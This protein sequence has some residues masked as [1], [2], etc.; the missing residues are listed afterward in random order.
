MSTDA[1]ID[2]LYN[3]ILAREADAEGKAYWLDV[4]DSRSLSAAQATQVFLNSGEFATTISPLASLYY[5]TFNRAPDAPGL[6]FWASALQ[7]GSTFISISE[8][9]MASAEYQALYGGLVDNGDFIDQV[10]SNSFARAADAAG[11]AYWLAE[12]D[13]G[14]SRAELLGHFARSPELAALRGEELKVIAQ[15][16]SVLRADPGPGEFADAAAAT[17]PLQLTEQLYAHG[18][19]FGETVPYFVDTIAPTVSASL[20]QLFALHDRGVHTSITPLND[21]DNY[22][23]SSIEHHFEGGFFKDGR[24]QQL[25]TNGEVIAASLLHLDEGSQSGDRTEVAEVTALGGG[26]YVLTWHRTQYSADEPS[27]TRT[28]F[29]QHVNADGSTDNHPLIQIDGTAEEAISW[30]LTTALGS[31]GDY[32]VAWAGYYVDDADKEPRI[33]LQH[34]DPQGNPAGQQPLELALSAYAHGMHLASLDDSGHF[35]LSWHADTPASE[36]SVFGP[37]FNADGSSTGKV[38]EFN[39]DVRFI[40]DIATLGNTG[41]YAVIW[42]GLSSGKDKGHFVQVF[43]ADGSAATSATEVESSYVQ[44]TALG[45]SGEFVLTWASSFSE[46]WRTMGFAQKYN[47]DGT[48]SGNALLQLSDITGPFARAGSPDVSALG[49]DGAYVLTWE[50]KYATAVQQ[51]GADG[52]LDGNPVYFQ[53]GRDPDISAVGNKG[54]YALVWDHD[55]LGSEYSGPLLQTFN[56]DGTR[57]LDADGIIDTSGFVTAISNEQGQAYLVNREIVVTSVLDITGSADELWNESSIHISSSQI[58]ISATGLVDG[59][60]YVYSVDEAGNLSQPAEQ[61][62]IIGQ[63]LDG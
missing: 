15:Y 43:N 26:D 22:V 55:A 13:R 2:Q 41:T 4:I 62:I 18:F 10:Y 17:S 39:E 20:P 53:A 24:V 21:G 48:T 42:S 28:I 29:I 50:G 23:L 45:N 11:H 54:E 47:A 40:W 9:F 3:N 38:T 35:V 49:T 30:P 27:Y 6:A 19:Y 8:N 33:F 46:S 36:N 56:A 25:D 60:Y 12:L 37:I 58:V 1:F 61:I 14:L 51:V 32:L 34:F 7:A 44:I 63:T 31:N 59:D 52:K 5:T 16:H 57:K